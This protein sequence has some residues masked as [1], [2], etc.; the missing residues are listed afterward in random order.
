V[1]VLL[2]IDLGERRI[3]LAT[4]DTASG[5]IRPLSTLTRG[6]TEHDIATLR[7]LCQELGAEAVVVG[8]PLHIDGSESWQSARTRSWAAALADGLDIP[9]SLRDER[10]TSVAAESRMG[11]RP[12]GRSGGAPSPQARR[13]WRARIDREAAADIV[14]RE[15]DERTSPAGPA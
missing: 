1:S 14:Q 9:V 2:G 5:A 13:A 3:G 6:T 8:L 7:R 4:G 11:R 12:R 15:L 10:L